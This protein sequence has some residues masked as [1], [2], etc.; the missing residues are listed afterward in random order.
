[1]SRLAV[2]MSGRRCFRR[3]R[4]VFAVDPRSVSH[5]RWDVHLVL[6]PK[7]TALPN[8]SP[9]DDH[10]NPPSTMSVMVVLT[11]VLDT[12]SRCIRFNA[13]VLVIIALNQDR[14]HVCRLHED[15]NRWY[16]RQTLQGNPFPNIGW[17]LDATSDGTRIVVG[18]PEAQGPN[19]KYSGFF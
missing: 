1:M 7:Q 12:L 15:D 3:R 6:G 10:Q 9:P 13:P 17:S 18:A 4:S 8:G 11:P 2:A 16:V 14:V 19:V 5:T